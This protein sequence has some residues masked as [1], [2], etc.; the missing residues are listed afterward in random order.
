VLGWGSG[1]TAG[2]GGVE[3]G[4]GGG[5]MDEEGDGDAVLPWEPSMGD[6]VGPTTFGC[7]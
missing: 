1:V 7:Q 4:T 3:Q 2:G 6:G 5:E